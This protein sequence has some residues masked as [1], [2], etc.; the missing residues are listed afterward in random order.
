[1]SADAGWGTN[2]G[3]KAWNLDVQAYKKIAKLPQDIQDK[4]IS[5]MAQNVHNKKVIENL[6]NKIINQN[7]KIFK[8][9]EPAITWILP[10]VLK[11]LKENQNLKVQSPV[12]S[13]EARQVK[14][15]L[16][17]TKIEKQK[18]TTNQF[19][20]I[21]DVLNG[22]YN[23]LFYDTKI[24]AIIYVKMLTKGEIVDGRDCIAIPVNINSKRTD[25]PVNYI[26]TTKRINYDNILKDKRYIKIE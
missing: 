21:Y 8:V 11:Y 25:R 3:T 2:L 9:E 6:T 13:F 26:G 19:L 15:S 18:L 5:D 12:I 14:H 17:K 7:F 23:E 1:M 4:F 22:N 24:S 20:Q 10:S 16:G